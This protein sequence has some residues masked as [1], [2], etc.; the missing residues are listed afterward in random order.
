M[1]D[2]EQ[3]VR[4]ITWS[5]C[6]TELPPLKEDW[7]GLRSPGLWVS[8]L[9]LSQN[10]GQ[11]TFCSSDYFTVLSC[12][13]KNEDLNMSCRI[14]ELFTFLSLSFFF[15]FGF[16]RVVPVVYESSQDGGW[17][18]GRAASLPPQPQQHKIWAASATYNTAHSN[19]RSLIHWVRPGIKPTTSWILL[20][21][22]NH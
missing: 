7:I 17:I 9:S 16:L 18:R 20:G 19:T 10:T 13:F 6:T 15:F 11:V 22:V 14:L 12:I 4:D 1:L 21:F 8:F 3:L 5:Y 2:I